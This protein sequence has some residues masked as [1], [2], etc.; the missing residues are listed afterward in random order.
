MYLLMICISSQDAKIE[1]LNTNKTYQAGMK[2]QAGE[3]QV[4]VSKEGFE[5]QTQTVRLSQ[6]N[7]SFDVT[8]EPR[9]LQDETYTVNGVSFTMKAI[10]AGSFQMGSN[11]GDEDEKPVH[12][13][14]IDGFYM[15]EH[16]V[17]WGMYQ[18]CINAGVCRDNQ[19]DGGDNGW[20]KDNRPVIEVSY[21][22]IIKHYIPWLNRKMGQNFRLP[23]EAEWEYAARAGSATKYSWGN[24]VNCSQALYGHKEDICGGEPKT[25]PV[26]SFKPNAFGLYDMHGNVMEWVQDCWHDNYNNAPN[27]GEAWMNENG[28]YCDAAV[29]R[30]GSFYFTADRMRSAER[31]RGFRDGESNGIGFR[32][33]HDQ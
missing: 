16:E 24:S 8:L 28:G 25:V 7:N 17:T 1:L 10:P 5:S 9:K 26:A 29:L 32:L 22:D 4:K 3:Y 20:G 14:N 27:N 31:A 21:N 15:M 2:L 23:T 18:P 13:V 6:Y 12:T 11:D 19:S 33:A 30:G